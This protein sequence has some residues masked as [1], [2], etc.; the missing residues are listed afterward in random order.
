MQVNDTFNHCTLLCI[1]RIGKVLFLQGE[2]S[3]YV[4]Y[5][6][7]SLPVSVEATENSSLV[8]MLEIV[9]FDSSDSVFTECSNSPPTLLAA[10]SNH[11]ATPPLRVTAVARNSRADSS[12]IFSPS[13]PSSL[14]RGWGPGTGWGADHIHRLR[15][16]S[17][18]TANSSDD[19]PAMAV[20]R[21][22]C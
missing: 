21:K 8:Y 1:V 19:S 10:S 22:S 9:S 12:R 17:Q 11:V 6:Q 7:K 16:P 14:E 5:H 15:L 3:V 13:R 20:N 2:W 4:A 18:S